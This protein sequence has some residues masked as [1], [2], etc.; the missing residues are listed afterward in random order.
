MPIEEVTFAVFDRLLGAIGLIREGKKRRKE[1]TDQALYA[2]YAALNETKAYVEKLNS[3]KRRNR[4]TEWAIARLW[5]DAS[6]PLRDV[7]RDLANRCFSKGSYWMEPNTWN[8]IKV[9]EKQIKLEQV[10]ESTRKLLMKT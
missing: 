6:V 5:H 9:E 10:M 7:D 3:G 1:R 4:K 2:L 8:E